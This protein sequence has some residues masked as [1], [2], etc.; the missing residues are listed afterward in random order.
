MPVR[1]PAD[2]DG[3]PSAAPVASAI[4]DLDGT[5]LNGGSTARWMLGLLERS[6]LRPLGALR[7]RG[8]HAI[9]NLQ[10]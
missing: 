5:L 4:F 9:Q 2:A 7:A 3:S 10:G 8:L 6:K 1:G